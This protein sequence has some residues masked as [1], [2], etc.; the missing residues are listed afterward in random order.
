MHT[1]SEQQQIFSIALRAKKKKKVFLGCKTTRP[2]PAGPLLEC[3]IALYR[4]SLSD[5]LTGQLKG[6][7]GLNL[8]GA[9]FRCVSQLSEI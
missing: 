7:I 4:F 9:A 8:R 3:A 6:V 1:S 2:A 5:C